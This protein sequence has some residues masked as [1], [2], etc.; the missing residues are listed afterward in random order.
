MASGADSK[1]PRNFCSALLRSVMSAYRAHEFQIICTTMHRGMAYDAKILHRTIRHQQ[2]VLKIKILLLLLRRI[3]DPL[4]GFD[5]LWMNSFEY[6]FQRRFG[7]R[8]EVENA[9]RFSGPI[10]FPTRNVP[11][12]TA[13][14]A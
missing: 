9:I 12:E 6:Q 10:D 8:R 3:D 13:G 11:P 5:V 7:R 2:P 1:S 4:D 14:V